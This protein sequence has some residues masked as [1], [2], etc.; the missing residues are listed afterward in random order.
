LSCGAGGYRSLGLARISAGMSAR[1]VGELLTWQPDP[2]MIG[3]RQNQQHHC[4]LLRWTFPAKRASVVVT[5]SEPD[6]FAP[7]PRQRL[8]GLR[9][10]CVVA[11]RCCV[12][13]SERSSLHVQ[14]Q[15]CALRQ[16]AVKKK[17]ADVSAAT[18]LPSSALILPVLSPILPLPLMRQRAALVTRHRRAAPS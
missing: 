16:G 2:E 1:A 15:T 4:S 18:R 5:D 8:V 9:G 14:A 6:G 13:T 12:G 10:V 7:L 11:A 3:R 17:N